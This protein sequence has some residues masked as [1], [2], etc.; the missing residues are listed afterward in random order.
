[1]TLSDVNAALATSTVCTVIALAIFGVFKARFTGMS[2][3]R[4]ALQ[5]VLTG[6]I[7]AAAAFGL[8]RLIH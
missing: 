8:T 6:G 3:I 2:P 5:T 7:A 1:M 4:G